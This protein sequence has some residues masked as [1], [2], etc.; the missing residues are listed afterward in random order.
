MGKKHNKE[1]YR[2]DA[3]RE[4]K[5][6]VLVK[7]GGR[8]DDA[9]HKANANAINIKIRW[10]DAVEGKE[11]GWLQ[12]SAVAVSCCCGYDGATLGGFNPIQ[13]G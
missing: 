3:G 9:D 13:F 11:R 10:D 1:R 8:S 5:K 4:K 2:R 6:S 7:E 12:C